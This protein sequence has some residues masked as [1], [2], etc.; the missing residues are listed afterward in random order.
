MCCFPVKQ[1][2]QKNVFW[3]QAS[4]TSPQRSSGPRR[5]GHPHGGPREEDER[6]RPVLQRCP[7]PQDLVRAR[8]HRLAWYSSQC[9]GGGRGIAQR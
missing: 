9:L 6:R 5:S 3:F 8:R 4:E 2:K 7:Q 1:I